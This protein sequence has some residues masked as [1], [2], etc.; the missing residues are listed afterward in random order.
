LYFI[1]WKSLQHLKELMI[2]IKLQ[3]G[4]KFS[5][6]IPCMKVGNT[7]TSLFYSWLTPASKQTPRCLM[8]DSLSTWPELNTIHKVQV[9]ERLD[10]TTWNKQPLIGFEMLFRTE[11]MKFTSITCHYLGVLKTSSQKENILEDLTFLMFFIG[12]LYKNWHCS[13]FW[14]LYDIYY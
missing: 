2:S 4:L 7:L 5:H 14:D 12:R 3:W 1:W 13:I 10:R 6:P 8:L 11:P 9:G